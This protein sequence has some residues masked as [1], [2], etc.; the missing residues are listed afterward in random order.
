MSAANASEPRPYAIVAGSPGGADVLSP[1]EFEP[2]A[3]GAGEVVVRQTAIGLNFLDIYYRSGLYAWPVERD[4]VPGAEAVGVVE[5]VGEG[6]WVSVG[7]RVAYTARTGAYTTHRV[8]CADQLVSVPDEIDD[9][10]AAAA[11]LK[12]LTA[13]YLLHDSFRAEAGDVVLFHAAAGGVGLIAGQWLAAKGVTAIGT[14]GGAEKCR[15]AAANGFEHTI[16]YRHEDFVARVRELTGGAGVAAVYDSVG[17]DTYPGSLHCLKTF[18]TLVCF[19]Q[20]SGLATAFRI[21]DLAAGSFRL[22]RPILFHYTADRAWLEGAARD[23]FRL[24]A[25]GVLRVPVNQT[26]P[27]ADAA[28]AHDALERRATTGCTVL[29]P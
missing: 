6:A 19:G 10:T 1:R 24:I 17:N 15:R 3:P 29:I 21:Q 26:F 18:G 14:A 7:D 4:L 11:L 13:H 23:L 25:D 22:T 8:I 9:A 28:A 2:K 12:G 5:A 20:S 16:D 27:L